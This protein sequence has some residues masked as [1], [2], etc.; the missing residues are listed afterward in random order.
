MEILV[1]LLDERHDEIIERTVYYDENT[2]I[3][4]LCINFFSEYDNVHVYDSEN[5]YLQPEIDYYFHKGVLR[6]NQPTKSV[7]VYDYL[8]RFPACKQKGIYLM[9]PSG[10]IGGGEIFDFVCDLYNMINDFIQ[11]HPAAVYVVTFVIEK[12]KEELIKWG[13]K[14][15]KDNI[16]KESLK[17]AI[18][19]RDAWTFRELKKALEIDDIDS[20]KLLMNILGYQCDDEQELFLKDGYKDIN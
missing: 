5:K 8:E 18:L 6:W 9:V 16:S 10:G 13:R 12:A 19:S 2:K 4:D 1:V 7:L 15:Q 17:A 20:A 3:D 14:K 11:N